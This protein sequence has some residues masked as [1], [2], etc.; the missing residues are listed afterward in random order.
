MGAVT[1]EITAEVVAWYA[2]IVATIAALV[3]LLNAWRDRARIQ[4]SVNSRMSMFPEDPGE[5]GKS[6]TLITVSNRG[7]RPLTVTH[8]WFEI[9]KETNP[10]LLV[11]D[12]LKKGPQEV[13]E[14]KA[15]QYIVQ[16]TDVDLC[17]CKYVC[18]SDATGRTFRRK[19]A[20]V[21]T[22]SSRE[23]RPGQMHGKAGRA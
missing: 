2:A 10:R 22:K 11:A 21:S 8:V 1:V 5:E 20:K 16:E 3:S 18:V 14:G 13:T 7:R 9:Q 17:A 23:D 15:V 4:V 19:V 6:Y 12:S